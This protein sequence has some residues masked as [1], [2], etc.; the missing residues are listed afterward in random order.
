MKVT[1]TLLT[2]DEVSPG[3]L[4]YTEAV[5]RSAVAAAQE[6]IAARTMV[7][8]VRGAAYPPQLSDVTH[9]V[10]GLWMEGKKL[11]GSIELLDTP[12]GVELMKQGA[13]VLRLF[14]EGLGTTKDG[15]VVAFELTSLTVVDPTCR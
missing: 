3:G 5:L 8:S 10:T 11:V 4:I 6:K 15:V 14:T 13:G 12:K 2:A 7:G 1:R 9:I